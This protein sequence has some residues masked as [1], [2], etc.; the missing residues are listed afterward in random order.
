M[1]VFLRIVLLAIVWLGV[2]LHGQNL[3]G[4]FT[5]RVSD[6]SGASVSGAVVTATNTASATAVRTLTSESGLYRLAGL[7]PGAY[8]LTVEMSGFQAQRLEGIRLLA[9]QR[10]DYSLQ[11]EIASVS[12]EVAV[13]ATF[14][15]MRTVSTHG[16]RGG[17]LTMEETSMLPV[18]QGSRGR[19]FGGL[20]LN[21]GGVTPGRTHAP[22]VAN[23]NRPL[24]TSNLMV[25]SAEFNDV[26]QGSVMGRGTTE[27]PVSLEAVESFE[28]Q[29]SSFKADV[30]RATGAVVN[31]VT[32]SGGNQ[33]RGS[34]YY[35]GQNSALNARNALLSENPPLRSHVP[36]MTIGGPILRNRLFFF[37]NYENPV[38]NTYSGSTRVQTLLPEQRERA[39]PAI[40]PLVNLF[41]EPNIPGTNLY[42]VNIPNPQTLKSIV[43]RVD[44]IL[45]DNHRLS[46][47]QT[48]LKAIGYKFT[49][50]PDAARDSWNGNRLSALALDSTLRPNVLNQVKVAYSIYQNPQR[51]ENPFFGDPALHG[52]VG[53][54]RVTGLSAITSFRN[55][56]E[57]TT[58]NYSVSDDLSIVRGSHMFKM[59]GIARRL[60]GN[61]APET[62]FFGTMA[63]RNV[64]DFLAGRPLSYTINQGDPRLDLRWSEY[65]AYLQDDWRVLPNLTLNLG[66]RYE[67]F[68]VPG[69]KY[70][71]I[72]NPYQPDRNNFAPRF[73][74][75]YNPNGSLRTVLRG[76]YGV[77]Y[78]PHL[79]GMVGDMRFAPPLVDSLT[80]ASP[81]LPPSLTG[82][83]VGLNRT[84]IDQGLLQPLIQ[85]WNLTVERSVTDTSVLAVAYVGSNGTHLTRSRQPNGGPN[86]ARSLRPDPTAGVLTRIEG[87]ASSSFH[88]LQVTGR[89]RLRNG[90]MWRSAYTWGSAFDDASAYANVP[91]SEDNLRLDRG[92]SDFHV[93]HLWN[94]HLLYPLPWLRSHWLAGGW[95]VS[96]LM[97]ARSGQVFSILSNTN[98]LNGTLNNRALNIPGSILRDGPAQQPLRLA[99][100]VVAADLVTG[101]GFLGT[102]PRNS[103]VSPGIMDWNLALMKTFTVTERVRAEFRMESFNFTNRVNYGVPVN[104][105]ADPL[106]GTVQSAGDPR[107]FQYSLRLSF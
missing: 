97:T 24:G 71:K 80:V 74:F 76:G 60:H 7:A 102:L 9:G 98:N 53:S 16:A 54:L 35:L 62:N 72:T 4:E 22:F 6:G 33:W 82:A 34:V 79:M 64:N 87:S 43:G 92:L 95:Q 28:A 66:M 61:T 45:T 46:Y 27:Q 10:A 63:F 30:G 78:S 59:G 104:N 50:I 19:N 17:A 73:G 69:D 51:M 86:L 68:S 38:R 29:T 23:G 103:E 32:K 18:L 107:Q 3:G 14:E 100:G 13:T 90:L 39:I 42:E 5:G 75:A 31:L 40:R 48:F 106:F 67:Y 20:M 49:A 101:A 105:I 55:N 37:G 91:L 70:G 96:A 21:M 36:G 15:E 2:T 56:A 52:L 77:Y 44:A 93:R 88:S 99:P 1:R 84:F 85:N 12:E 65:G 11:L 83:S 47:R 58:H 25:D 8:V 81:G 94:G 26:L 89:G 41:P 57:L